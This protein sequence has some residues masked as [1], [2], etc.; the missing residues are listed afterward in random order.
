MSEREHQLRFV[1]PTLASIRTECVCGWKAECSGP[2]RSD[3]L[4]RQVNTHFLRAKL[5]ALVPKGERDR[6]DFAQ[7][8]IEVIADMLLIDNEDITRLA[9]EELGGEVYAHGRRYLI[10]KALGAPRK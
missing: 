4:E 6:K 1:E 8:A 5:E 3:Q 7:T 9:M 2:N 10:D